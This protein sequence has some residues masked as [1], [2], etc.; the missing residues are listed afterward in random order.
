[1]RFFREYEFGAVYADAT[2]FPDTPTFVVHG[3]IYQRYRDLGGPNGSLGWPSSD[4]LEFAE[5]G[6]VTT[7][8]NGAIYWWPDTGAIELGNIAVR[9]RGLYSF[10]ETDEDEFGSTDDEPMVILALVPAFSGM[11]STFTSQT[12]REVDAGESRE[13][14]VEIYQGLPYGLAIGATLIEV[15]EGSRDVYLE[16]VDQIVHRAGA[17]VAAASTGIPVVG[18][19]VA[20]V[21]AALLN[22][23]GDDLA[24]WIN[25]LL[26]TADDV[27]DTQ[28]FTITAKQ[29]VT[30]ARAPRQNLEGIEWQ[31]ETPLMSG[32]G[33]SYK[34]YFDIAVA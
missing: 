31:L 1:M 16:K 13:D 14:L 9:Y 33:A 11:E 26:G 20:V 2:D 6:K 7:F 4:E 32:N 27:L 19:G 15:D 23:F 34:A 3:A 10:G 5:G 25:E 28:S 17:G 21:L 30:L 24:R 12:Y 8:E 29:M 18:P 22:E